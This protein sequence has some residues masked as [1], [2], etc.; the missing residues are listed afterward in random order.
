D[1]QHRADQVAEL[2]RPLVEGRADAVVGSRY[3]APSGYQTPLGRRM[4]QRLLSAC[5]STL[6]RRTVTD[7]TSGFWAFGPAAVE[8]LAHAHPTGYPEPELLLLLQRHG[9]RVVEVP[10]QMRD[11]AAGRSTLTLPRAAWALAR[12]LVAMVVVPLRAIEAHE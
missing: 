8:R 12:F 11:R 5:L 7:P 1:G 2:L 9:L 6:A 10:V 3:L 4:G